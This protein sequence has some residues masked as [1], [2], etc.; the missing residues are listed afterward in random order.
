M[1]KYKIILVLLI[2]SFF[3]TSFFT[4]PGSKN[5]LAAY[6]VK[7]TFTGYIE[8]YGD[9]CHVNDTGK[10]IL[11]GVLEGNENLSPIFYFGNLQLSIHLDICS[12]RR[13]DGE[14]KFCVMNVNGSGPVKTELE[15]HYIKINYDSTLG[16]FKRKVNGTCDPAEMIEEQNMIP[17]ESI[18]SI[19]NGLELTMLSRTLGQLQVNKEYSDRMEY[20]I[21]KV[22]VLRKIR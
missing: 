9:E 10:V 17:N 8:L 21:V 15:G 4:N 5:V 22:Q 3:S 12:V 13:V 14:D 1:K 19:F 20:G 2:V 7:F 18:A 6:E 16:T 11:S